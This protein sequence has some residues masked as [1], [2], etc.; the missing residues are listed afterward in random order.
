LKENQFIVIR[1]GILSV[2]VALYLVLEN[3]AGMRLMKILVVMTGL[4]F[5]PILRRK[6]K[7]RKIE[8]GYLILVDVGLIFLLSLLSRYLINYYVITLYLLLMVEAGFLYKLKQ[9]KYIMLII[10][11]VTIY[12]VLTY[13]YYRKNFGTLSE[14]FFLLLIELV[15]L[16]GIILLKTL[17]EEKDKQ[18]YLLLDIKKKNKDLMQASEKIEA[19]KELEIKNQIARDIHDTFGHDMM[20]LIMEMEMASILI[21]TDK[22]KALEILERAKKSAREGM[23][24]IRKVVEALREEDQAILNQPL[25]EMIDHYAKRLS[26]QVTYKIDTHLYNYSEKVKMTIYRLVQ[27]SMTN[28]VRH[29]KADHIDIMIY[30]ETTRIHFI[31]KDNG[32]G[33]D[34]IIPG[35]GLKGM[36]ERVTKLE[37]QLMTH[38]GDGFVIS[39]YIE[40]END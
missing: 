9:V 36:E 37:G 18:S 28:S 14:V 39:G 15:I 19:L 27:E 26:I 34:N 33:S 12:H 17:K 38:S 10:L 31:I 6:I 35:F 29:G 25:E 5:M 1:T 22:K 40:V 24:T 16:L 7:G 20:A 32:S 13:Y 2:I 8:I 30:Q 3:V 23:R 4:F 11:G 21:E